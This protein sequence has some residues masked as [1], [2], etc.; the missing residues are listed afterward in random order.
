MRN[1]VKAQQFGKNCA[2]LSALCFA[3]NIN[4]LILSPLFAGVETISRDTTLKNIYWGDLHTH[5]ELSFD[6]T[7]SIDSLYHFAITNSKLDFVLASDHDIQSNETDWNRSK[8]K[9]NEYYD[10]GEFVTF[11][12]YEWT[13]QA[14]T[15]GGHRI[16]IYPENDASRFS[17]SSPNYNTLEKLTVHVQNSGG[18]LLIAHPDAIAHANI[19]I[20]RNDVQ[21]GIEVV[22]SGFRRFEYF[23]N[24]RAHPSQ[25]PDKSVRDALNNGHT[26]GLMGVSDSHQCRPGTGGLT[27]VLSKE[28]TR[29]SVF[30]AIKNRK[31]F[32]TTG[33]RIKVRFYSENL[34]MGDVY[35][36]SPGEI[37]MFPPKLNFE[38]EGTSKLSNV[39]IIKNSKI[40]YNSGEINSNNYQSSYL[41][42]TTINH[43]TYFYLK[44]TQSDNHIAWSSPIF[45]IDERTLFNLSIN[46]R[47][48]SVT[49]F[50]NSVSD[51]LEIKYFLYENKSVDLTLYDILG[52]RVLNVYSGVQNSGVNQV[53]SSV[54]G[55]SNGTYLINL[56]AGGYSVATK[57]LILR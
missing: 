19:G 57:I 44:V 23:G 16:V 22:G 27:A 35:Y 34:D 29:E 7:C 32:A 48:P 9:A 40:V 17:F 56:R 41:D 33:A 39:Q 24:E 45:F 55:L 3:F 47:K 43:N 15:S 10:P 6:A 26:L 54:E 52:R 31:V 12:G 49:G 36:F 13:G 20:I 37:P 4:W 46:E 14:G 18:L 2:V 53:F 38:I 28:L 50:Y 11:L 1:L 30:K 21:V 42:E 51:Q 8:L 25:V 5:S